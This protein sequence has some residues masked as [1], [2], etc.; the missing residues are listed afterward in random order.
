M[1]DLDIIRLSVIRLCGIIKDLSCCTP[2]G[3]MPTGDFVG[4]KLKYFYE[5]ANQIALELERP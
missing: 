1:S 2:S 4:D 3:R 5:E